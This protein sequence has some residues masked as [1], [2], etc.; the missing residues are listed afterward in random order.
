MPYLD[1]CEW[2]KRRLDE[3]WSQQLRASFLAP[4][5]Q[6]AE[7]HEFLYQLDTRIVLTP[8]F[9]RIYDNHATGQSHGTILVKKY[10]DQDI[11]EYIRRGDR[12]ILK[13]HGSIDD[14]HR[15][16][17]TRN[18]YATARTEHASFYRLL[19]SLIMTNTVLM[20]GVG[21]DDPDFR[22]LFE[23]NRARFQAA[24][25]HYMTFGG[26]PNLDLVQTARETMGIKLLPYSP[27]DN[28]T[29]LVTSLKSLVDKVSDERTALTRTMDW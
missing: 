9:D 13:A 15:M 14:P 3:Q 4:K 12:L 1:A 19:D 21:L 18:Q 24:L 28:H 5:Y 22:L 2:L 10:S 27:R 16:I 25:P 23:D 8:N 20:I 17:F 7:I 26:T 6:P 11:V 29:A